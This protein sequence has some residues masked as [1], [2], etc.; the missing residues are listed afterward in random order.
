MTD[1]IGI[2][3]R[4]FLN[5]GV[6]TVDLRD[7]GTTSVTGL[8][9]S[10]SCQS[11]LL[12]VLCNEKGSKPV[13]ALNSI[14]AHVQIVF[15]I[16][17]NDRV[18]ITEFPVLLSP[19]HSV[20]W[21]EGGGSVR[22]SPDHHSQVERSHTYAPPPGALRLLNLHWSLRGGT[23]GRSSEEFCCWL[24]HWSRIKS[25]FK[26]SFS[27]WLRGYTWTLSCRRSVGY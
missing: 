11:F 18:Y 20:Y 3:S 26:S 23:D 2:W 4:F 22:C 14:F 10:S 21:C 13:F 1:N 17:S 6:I 25:R 27:L 19:L 9:C 8:L 7:Q 12:I 15:E 5:T 24:C 16:T